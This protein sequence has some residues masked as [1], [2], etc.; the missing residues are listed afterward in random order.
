VSTRPSIRY[1]R[2]IYAWIRDRNG[3]G[4]LRPGI[5]ITSDEEITADGPLAV[6]AVT[7]AFGDPPP[8]SH[9]PVPWHPEGHP[10]TRLNRR[11]AAVVDWLSAIEPD[12]IVGFGGDAPARVMRLIQEKLGDI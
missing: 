12:D 10:V 2:I 11:S 7:T 4:K 1:G 8:A 5:I 3:F 9:N 6:A